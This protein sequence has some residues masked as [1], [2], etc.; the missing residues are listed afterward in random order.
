M[1]FLKAR[2]IM[3]CA[4]LVGIFVVGIAATAG[5]QTLPVTYKNSTYILTYDPATKILEC[6][7]DNTNCVWRTEISRRVPSFANVA[8]VATPAGPVIVYTE[9]NYQTRFAIPHFRTG[10]LSV[11]NSGESLRGAVGRGWLLNCLFQVEQYGARAILQLLE[12]QSGF[13][14]REYKLDINMWGTHQTL[15]K[16]DLQDWTTGATPES[17]RVVNAALKFQVDVP[18]GFR[19]TQVDEVS[20]AMYG[21]TNDVFMTIFSDSGGSPI[22]ELG[23]AY[24]AELGVNVTHRSME[25]L[26]SGEPAYLLMGEGTINGVPSL[27]VGVACSNGAHTWVIPYT[28]RADAADAYVGAFMD[29]LNSFEPT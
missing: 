14:M 12:P 6:S 20:Y 21:P 19:G 17:G 2:R 5:A 8:A 13:K 18:R 9:D 1:S 27:H 23:E 29:M 4:V 22:E 15:E 7:S 26:D 28:G 24:M 3:I 10:H 25:Q 11:E 16:S